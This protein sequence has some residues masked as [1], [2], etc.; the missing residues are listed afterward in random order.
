MKYKRQWSA[1]A[2]CLCLMAIAGIG[3][4]LHREQAA[5]ASE[6]MI[7]LTLEEA[8]NDAAFG[9]LFPTVILAGYVSEEGTAAIYDETVLKADFYNAEI[10]AV[11]IVTIAD[12][13]WFKRQVG[14]VELNTVLYPD[15]CDGDSRIYIDGDD[16]IIEYYFINADIAGIGNFS[17]M[18][19][20]ASF[21][22]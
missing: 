12:K 19:K 5:S 9:K 4:I 1:A 16:Q 20:S 21:F 17:E 6:P 15:G 10:D 22:S 14:E 8:A 11:C 3:L 13:E 2:V 18:V 7:E